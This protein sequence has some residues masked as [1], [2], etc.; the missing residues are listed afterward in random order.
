ME[1]IEILKE[2]FKDVMTEE[3]EKKIKD[4]IELSI[5]ERVTIE[6]EKI[7]KELEEQMKNEVDSG[8]AELSERL[9]IYIDKANEEL[10]DE[11]LKNI[12]SK[13]KVELAEAIFNGVVKTIKE[14]NMNIAIEEK[15]IIKQL[16]GE[17]TKLEESIN[18]QVK[19]IEESQKQIFE[20]EKALAVKDLTE[21]LTDVQTEKVIAMV[22]NVI[23]EDIEDFKSKV[24]TAIEMIDEKKDDDKKYDV[25]EE[26]FDDNKST[27][28]DI[29]LP[30][31]K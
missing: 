15:E 25:F 30:K 9:N 10:I 1:I 4:K 19:E 7:E 21:S 23:V 13:T 28:V 5:S 16:E 6:K 17:K 20:Y 24:S 31:Y 26:N 14:N 12:E 22:K 8:I 27:P 29:Y 3:I 18:E 2:H 11:N